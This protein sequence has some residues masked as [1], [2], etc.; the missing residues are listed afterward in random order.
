VEPK[1]DHYKRKASALFSRT[2]NHGGRYVLLTD[3][4]KRMLDGDFGSGTQIS[5]NLLKKFGEAFDAERIVKADVVHLTTNIPT[6]LLEEMTEG[7]EQVG[8]TAGFTT[9]G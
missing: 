4:Q 1:D 3:E 6:D 7:V 2:N 9:V 5:M 8:V